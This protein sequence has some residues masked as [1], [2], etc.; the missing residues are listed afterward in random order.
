MDEEKL[1]VED[2]GVSPVLNDIDG[3]V[4]VQLGD[5]DKAV[6]VL[7]EDQPVESPSDIVPPITE[8][9][10]IVHPFTEKADIVP[11]TTEEAEIVPPI[12]E[13]ADIVPPITEEAGHDD[14]SSNNDTPLLADQSDKDSPLTSPEVS[15]EDDVK[16]LENK[17][18]EIKSILNARGVSTAVAEPK[19]GFLVN[20]RQLWDSIWI[21]VFVIGTALVFFV[22]ARNS[23]TW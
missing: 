2:A 16:V 14:N 13:E 10:D 19:K 23:I 9:E 3:E 21:T 4:T 12:T 7:A 8:D 20:I 18:R 1:L 6:L 22:A 17:I 5:V 15:K 11:P